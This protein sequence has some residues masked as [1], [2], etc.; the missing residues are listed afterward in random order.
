M[1]MSKEEVMKGLSMSF[2]VEKAGQLLND[3]VKS[4]GLAVKSDYSRD[5]V[6]KICDAM[7]KRD[8]ILLKLLA[9]TL[10]TRTI[11]LKE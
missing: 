7:E 5:E 9:G 2:G 8:E 6:F 1:R 11:L 4:A 10:R 3:I